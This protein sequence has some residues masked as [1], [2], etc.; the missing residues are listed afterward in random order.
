MEHTFTRHLLPGWAYIAIK[1]IQF[2]SCIP[3]VVILVFSYC[4]ITFLGIK[5][6]KLFMCLSSSAVGALGE[7]RFISIC[8]MAL[9]SWSLGFR[10]VRLEFAALFS[11]LVYSRFLSPTAMQPMS[12]MHTVDLKSDLSFFSG[13]F[14]LQNG[15]IVGSHFEGQRE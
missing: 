5:A 10:D 8:T 15:S 9:V 13:D 11:A 1:M 2:I 6:L 14:L 4:Q 12:E 7:I 3:H